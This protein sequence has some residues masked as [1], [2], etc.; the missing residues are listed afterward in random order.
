MA[1]DLLYD[2]F[3]CEF[4]LGRLSQWDEF[5]E[6]HPPINT[7]AEFDAQYADIMQAFHDHNFVEQYARV[8]REDADYRAD[9][10]TTAQCEENLDSLRRWIY[11]VGARA[12]TAQ[13]D[14]ICWRHRA[15]DFSTLAR[16]ARSPM[17][18][19]I[20]VLLTQYKR[21]PLWN[22]CVNTVHR[23]HRTLSRTQAPL[24]GLLQGLHECS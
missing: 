15:Y 13:L 12:A 8:C 11:T 10:T 9:H 21:T 6:D 3:F 18:E 20:M 5:M 1:L 14:N 2:T 17:Q 16:N 22:I 7:F 4:P 24:A 23:G 19:E